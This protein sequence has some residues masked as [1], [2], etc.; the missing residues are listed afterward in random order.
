M[1]ERMVK[2]FVMKTFILKFM[3]SKMERPGAT[4]DLRHTDSRFTLS[5]RRGCF[6]WIRTNKH[7]VGSQTSKLNM[8]EQELAYRKGSDM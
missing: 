6:D 7:L 2:V 1:K 4:L 3:S 8:K 5:L